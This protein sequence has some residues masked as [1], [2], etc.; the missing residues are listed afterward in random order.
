MDRPIPVLT[1]SLLSAVPGVVHAFT[2]REGGVSPAPYHSLNLGQAPAGD[3]VTNVQEN[4]RRLT[5]QLG[6]QSLAAVHQVHGSRVV[7][8]SE[9]HPGCQADGVISAT[10]G[11]FVMVKVADCAPVLLARSDGT[12]VAAVHAGWRGAV[13]RIAS[14]AVRLLGTPDVVAAVG[15]CIGPCCFEV[16]QEVVDAATAVAGPSVVVRREGRKPHVDLAGIVVADLMDAGVAC[17]RVDVLRG[18]TVCHGE[19]FSHRRDQGLTGR[20]AGVI[21]R[22]C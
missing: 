12:K 22:V 2:G 9:A 5:A 21:G 14:Q 11:R 18:C 17:Q 7:D 16:G 3:D 4:V 20:Q 10:P 1:S 15:P 8:E 13:A 6:A 19:L